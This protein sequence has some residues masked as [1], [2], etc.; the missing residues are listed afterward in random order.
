MNVA[1]LLRAIAIL[2]AIV[3]AFDPGCVRTR[4]DRPLVAVLAGITATDSARAQ[5][6][7][8]ALADR[9][10][11][12]FGWLPAAD[13]VV[14][15]GDRLP[16]ALR[17]EAPSGPVFTLPPSR[18][19]P[20]IHLRA[21]RA[22]ARAR[23]GERIAL[24]A[25]VAYTAA[26]GDSLE[27]AVRHDGLLLAREAVAVP[28]GAAA[29]HVALAVLASDTGAIMLEV[30][31]ALTRSDVHAASPVLLA[32]H[33]APVRVF[34]HDTRPSWSG[35]FVRRAL[36]ADARVEVSSR[37]T[38]S[39]TEGAP[40]TMS[41]G[42]PPALAALPAP[43]ALDVVVVGAAHALDDRAV[44]ALD[45][46]VRAGGSAVLLLDDAPTARVQRW[47]AVPAWRRID[48]AVPQRAQFARALHGPAIDSVGPAADRAAPD[49]P[50]RG[51]Q[52]L[53]P[54]RL[55]AGS[56]PWLQLADSSPV[57]WSYR[58]GAGTVVVS[59][60]LDAWTFRE[61]A[62]SAFA[63]TW[64]RIVAEAAAR[65]AP[66][67][68]IAVRPAVAAPG[69]WREIEVHTRDATLDAMAATYTLTVGDAAPGTDAAR[70]VPQPI[71]LHSRGDGRW[72]AAWR[73]EAEHL[74][75]ARL[76]LSTAGQ[77]LA[78]APLR[79]ATSPPADDAPHRSVLT[80]LAAAT[81]GAVLNTDNLDALGDALDAAL[82]P[83]SRQHPW[84]PMRSPWWMF[85]FAGALLAEWWLRR[86][87]GRP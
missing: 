53:V 54:A 66:A 25:Y 51:R 41:E 1:R 58:L 52:W 69:A 24:D 60:A 6:V 20:N 83:A 3:A 68:S 56:E 45:R 11:I 81:D 57:V 74:G 17:R 34:S 75:A 35:T 80:A 12:V 82:S 14:L 73:D 31:A 65:V 8:R 61:T 72:G 43:P 71:E 28:P 78:T 15:L 87:A 44:D 59:G 33:E 26:P 37:T 38:I 32:V 85:P 64:P 55:P 13:A 2:I 70:M 86:R 10:T 76:V 29:R 27:L 30:S 42:A 7:E 16:E 18:T 47:L 67:V 4:R 46:W 19:T 39:R 9:S 5:A 40:I 77:P 79:S 63:R 36:S 23:V 48:Q 49:A 84:H 50:L 62:R 21:L 22:P